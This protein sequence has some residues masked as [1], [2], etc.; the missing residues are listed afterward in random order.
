MY[1]RTPGGAWELFDVLLDP[2]IHKGKLKELW[3]PKSESLL[4]VAAVEEV[5]PYLPAEERP[6]IEPK[7][8]AACLVIDAKFPNNRGTRLVRVEER[9]R[10]NLHVVDEDGRK[11]RLHASDCV[12]LQAK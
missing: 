4:G 11:L 1:R 6:R 3:Q 10:D 9:V 8:H 7:D 5:Y 12:R 2:P